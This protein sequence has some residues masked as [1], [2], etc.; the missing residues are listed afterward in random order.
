MEKGSVLKIDVK[1]AM[2]GKS[3]ERRRFYKFILIKA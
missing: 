3:F 1:A 2:E